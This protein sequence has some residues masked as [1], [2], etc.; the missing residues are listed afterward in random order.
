MAISRQDPR[1]NQKERTRAAIVDA[2]LDLMRAG[3]TPTV[4]AAAEA[5]KVSRATAYRYFP[6]QDSLLMELMSITPSTE[7]V[8]E[9]LQAERSQDPEER[10]MN[11]LDL[12]NH[13]V[14][15]EEGQYRA[16]LRIYMDT[17]LANQ[18]G[19]P[20]ELPRLRVGRRMRWLEQALEPLR[21]RMAESDLLRL[22]RAL[23]L[24]LGIDSVAIMRDVCG[25]EDDEELLH[26]LRWTASVILRAAIEQALAENSAAKF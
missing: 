20:E 3:T 17:W 4:Q 24:T 14:L 12:F 16:A 18:N 2:A 8:E 25:I 22:K 7:I 13:I 19:S 10:L 6:T 1:A 11:L 15:K 9:T 21:S 26:V 5:A 23:A